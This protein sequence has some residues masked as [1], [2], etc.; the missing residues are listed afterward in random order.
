MRVADQIAKEVPE[1]YEGKVKKSV[2]QKA[3]LCV[4]PSRPY[5][6]YAISSIY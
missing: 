4:R 6:R 1:E 5:H 3:Q 2:H